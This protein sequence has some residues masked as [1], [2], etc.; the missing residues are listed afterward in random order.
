MSEVGEDDGKGMV[1]YIES[2]RSLGGGEMS[3]SIRDGI[4]VRKPKKNEFPFRSYSSV[5]LSPNLSLLQQGLRS[6]NQV[7]QIR[8]SRQPL[9]D[10]APLTIATHPPTNSALLALFA[11]KIYFSLI[12][13]SQ[14]SF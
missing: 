6:L 13:V 14:R 5:F 11:C 2:V 1:S 10:F 4:C 12:L 7:Y 8:F 3:R 9:Q